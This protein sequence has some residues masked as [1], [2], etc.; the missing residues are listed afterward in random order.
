M[1]S[2]STHYFVRHIDVYQVNN[3]GIIDINARAA[4]PPT[5]IK[6]VVNVIIKT[7]VVNYTNGAIFSWIIVMHVPRYWP[8]WRRSSMCLRALHVGKT[9]N[10]YQ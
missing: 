2:D 5:T 1:L 10:D 4:N 7:G 9:G 8:S 3:A 6:A